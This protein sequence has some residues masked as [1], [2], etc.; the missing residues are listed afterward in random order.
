M[1][2]VSDGMRRRSLE[3]TVTDPGNAGAKMAGTTIRTFPN[4]AVSVIGRKIIRETQQ[5]GDPPP[6]RRGAN[7]APDTTDQGNS[8]R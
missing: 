7:L 2:D 5:R 8:T 4:G 3:E 6:N 1:I